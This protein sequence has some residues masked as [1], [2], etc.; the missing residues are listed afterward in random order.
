MILTKEKGA[1]VFLAYNRR[2][3]SSVL[4]AEKIIAE[5]GGITS[6]NFEFTEWAHVIELDYPREVFEN[7]FFV[8]STHVVDLAF[9]LGGE[10]KELSCFTFDK[11]AWHKPAFFYWCRYHQHRCSFSYQAN[12]NAPGRWGINSNFTTPSLF[13]RPM[14]KLQDSKY[15]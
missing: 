13:T 3:Y 12:W 2:F 14:E 11:L 9:F 10:P 6:F 5:D 8:N 7:W 15:W 4:A 1:N